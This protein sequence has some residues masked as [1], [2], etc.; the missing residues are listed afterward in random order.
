VNGRQNIGA[1]IFGGAFTPLDVEQIKASA[2]QAGKEHII[3]FLI[4]DRSKRIH[5]N[6]YQPTK[7]QA[8][9]REV[10][11]RA[12]QALDRLKEEGLLLSDMRPDQDTIHY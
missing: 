11:E 4:P 6:P 9:G 2:V 7:Q 5:N 1:V 10:G 12:L 3:R 8:Y